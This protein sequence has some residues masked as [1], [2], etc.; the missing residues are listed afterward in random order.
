[1]RAVSN[2]SSTIESTTASITA[3]GSMVLMLR[4]AAATV[5]TSDHRRSD[6]SCASSNA[7]ICCLTSL[8]RKLA[9]RASEGRRGEKAKKRDLDAGAA[10]AD[11]KWKEEILPRLTSIRADPGRPGVQRPWLRRV[12]GSLLPL[13]FAGSGLAGAEPSRL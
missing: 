12:H 10:G 8:A 4:A 13:A 5:E 1:M 2:P 11:L 3:R 7:P 9:K 6:S